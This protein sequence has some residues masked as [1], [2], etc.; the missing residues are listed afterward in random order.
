MSMLLCQAACKYLCLRCCPTPPNRTA[1]GLGVRAGFVPGVFQPGVVLVH[2][3]V[4]ADAGLLLRPCRE[5][6]S[7]QAAV[8]H[9]T[10]NRF[11]CARVDAPISMQSRCAHASVQGR[12]AQPCLPC[13]SALPTLLSPAC[14][15]PLRAATSSRAE[16]AATAHPPR[17]TPSAASSCPLTGGLAAGRIVHAAAFEAPPST[18]PLTAA[19][20]L[21]A[22]WPAPSLCRMA[23]LEASLKSDKELMEWFK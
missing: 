14:K 20:R 8:L 5:W 4:R 1:H 18:G 12:F 2:H 10:Y 19:L 9:Y 7:D 22:P 11:R 21:K 23:F 17:R 15:A 16:T 3:R 13:Q 6:S